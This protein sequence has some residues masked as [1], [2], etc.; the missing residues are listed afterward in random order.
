MFFFC[1]NTSQI[2]G[3]QSIRVCL[4]CTYKRTHTVYIYIYIYRK[5][6]H[7]YTFILLYLMLDIKYI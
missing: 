5:Y 3:V 2:K 1:S 6:L 4:L 7:V